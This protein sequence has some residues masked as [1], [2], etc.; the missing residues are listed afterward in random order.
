MRYFVFY[1]SIKCEFTND[2]LY[3]ADNDGYC[4]K[5]K[6]PVGSK[7]IAKARGWGMDMRSSPFNVLVKMKDDINI[8]EITEEEYF[9]QNL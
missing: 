5:H 6:T 3:I 1:S 2:V 9:L 4:E 7:K 8:V